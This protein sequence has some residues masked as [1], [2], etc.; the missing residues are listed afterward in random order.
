MRT[1]PR[2]PT[3]GLPGIGPS[4]KI[5]TQNRRDGDAVVQ[6]VDR[7]NIETTRFIAPPEIQRGFEAYTSTLCR[8]RTLN[9][10]TTAPAPAPANGPGKPS[11]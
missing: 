11:N 9:P 4:T 1:D 2:L 3:P 6:D 7:N 10:K 8:S 5:S